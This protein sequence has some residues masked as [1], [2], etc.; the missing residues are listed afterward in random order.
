MVLVQTLLSTFITFWALS[1]LHSYVAVPGRNQTLFHYTFYCCHIPYAMVHS[2]V[3]CG[4]GMWLCS[5]ELPLRVGLTLAEGQKLKWVLFL[6]SPLWYVQ[7]HIYNS[8]FVSQQVHL[9]PP[10]PSLLH[11]L[12]NL[13][14][15][16]PLPLTSSH[17]HT[18]VTWSQLSVLIVESGV[19][20]DWGRNEQKC[21]LYSL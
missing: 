8:F 15:W 14:Q 4:L 6:K 2:L 13:L 12:L 21:V 20:K 1:H 16:P 11:P 3:P 9:L 10:F 5:A 17:N 7:L 19:Y 18:Q